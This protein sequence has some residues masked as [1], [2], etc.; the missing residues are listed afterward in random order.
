V[1]FSL[2]LARKDLDLITELADRLGVPVPQ[3]RTNRTLI[4]EASAHV[5]GERDFS[6][7]A[8][9]LR[10]LTKEGTALG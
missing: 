4:E 1:G 9:H 2:D 5:G 8:S 6:A 3:A 10:E 7:V